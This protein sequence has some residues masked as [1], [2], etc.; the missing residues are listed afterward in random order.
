MG[1]G[2]KYALLAKLVGKGDDVRNEFRERIP[3]HSGRFAALVVAAL[4]GDDDAETGRSQRLNLFVPSI[5]K[6]RKAVEEKADRP[7]LGACGDRI[8]RDLAIFKSA[9]LQ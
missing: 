7:I 2:E 5:P 4:V 9:R 3:A 1:A 6:F 8:Q